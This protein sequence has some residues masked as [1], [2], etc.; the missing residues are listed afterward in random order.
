M[1]IN[2]VHWG[3]I[4]AAAVLGAATQGAIGFAGNLVT[5]P[6]LM[7]LDPRLIPAP[8]LIAGAVRSGAIV[9]RERSG[10][11][12]KLLA[13]VILGQVFGSGLG[14][15]M[16]SIVS[17]NNSGVLFGSL[18]LVGV[19]ASVVG[20][21]PVPN[22]SLAFT[23]G[24]ISGAMGTSAAIGGPVLALLYQ[25]AS[26]KTIRSS[27]SAL[28]LVGSCI[29]IS[30]LWMSG[31][32]SLYDLE[33]SAL[34]LPAQVVGLIIAVKLIKVTDRDLIRKIVLFLVALSGLASIV[35]ALVIK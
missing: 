22:N 6:A 29:S 35:Q 16:L 11:D 32:I 25:R 14:L 4:A 31:R 17:R 2:I 9:A 3:L 27:M 13:A 30:A 20:W 21:K 5:V 8:L 7:V 12:R 19:G 33:A 26:G 28:I 34:L 1:M 24:V 23:F 18:L 15:V 10:L